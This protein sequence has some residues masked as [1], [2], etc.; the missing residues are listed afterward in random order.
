MKVPTIVVPKRASGFGDD[1][2]A[3][4]RA[5]AP[6]DSSHSTPMPSRR[7]L[8]QRSLAIAGLLGGLGLLPCAAQAAWNAPAFDAKRNAD[9]LRALGL[10]GL[11]PAAAHELKLE[12]PQIAENGAV[13]PIV[14]AAVP[15]GTT[16]LVVLVEKNPSALIAAFELSEAI[17][18]PLQL[19]IKMAESSAVTLVAVGADDSLRFVERHVQVLIG[20][21]GP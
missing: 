18:L 14:V 7:H 10:G 21:C 15:A 17:E 11:Q 3:P 20:G 13:V 8:L 9:A 5:G 16:R 4:A 1:L 2:A 12:A 19:R 6:S